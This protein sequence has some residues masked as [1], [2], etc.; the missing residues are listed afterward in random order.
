MLWWRVDGRNKWSGCRLLCGDEQ[1]LGVVA[2]RQVNEE[3]EMIRGRHLVL[4]ISQTQSEP[5]YG[6]SWLGGGCV[7]WLA[8]WLAGW[9]GG[10]E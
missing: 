2:K 8:G 1:G 7:G 5:A 4:L 9:L 3:E 10:K 6:S